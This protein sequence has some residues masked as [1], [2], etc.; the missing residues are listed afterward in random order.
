MD[1]YV[2][3]TVNRNKF[4]CIYFLSN[5]LTSVIRDFDPK[6]HTELKKSPDPLE[7]SVRRSFRKYLKGLL[8]QIDISLIQ[9]EF[10]G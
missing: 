9:T 10:F 7:N 1:R 2:S 5:N 8:I 6:A 4:S 3:V